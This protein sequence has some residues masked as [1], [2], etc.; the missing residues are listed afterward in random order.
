MQPESFSSFLRQRGS[1]K[2][3]YIIKAESIV[4]DIEGNITEVLCT[5]DPES[6]SGSG[7]ASKRKVKGTLHWVTQRDSINAEVRIYDRLFN[8]S[9]P[10]KEKENF[11][12][13]K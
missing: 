1:L 7:A 5:Y 9:A 6:K 4:K 10:D 8:I 12:S 3:A 13:F 2:N 11:K